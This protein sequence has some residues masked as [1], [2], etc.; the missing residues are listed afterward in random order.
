MKIIDD[1]EYQTIK[2]RTHESNPSRIIVSVRKSTNISLESLSGKQ[3][4][5]SSKSGA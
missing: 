2:Y 1:G 5:T 3:G 4:K